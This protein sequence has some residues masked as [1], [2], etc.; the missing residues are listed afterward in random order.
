MRKEP[1][2][3]GDYVHVYNRGN[4]KLDIVRDEAD[5][6]RFLACLRYFNDKNP[7]ESIM[8]SFFEKKLKKDN[9]GL[10]MSDFHRQ[11]QV[12]G[13]PQNEKPQ[14]EIVHIIAYCLMPNHFHLLLKEIQFGGVTRFM[15][16]LGT[17]FTNYT[18]TK[19]KEAGRIFQGAYKAR[20]ITDEHY[21]QYADAYVQVLNPFEL[22]PDN[23][24]VKDFNR[25]FKQTIDY[26][27]SSLGECIGYR[28]FEI[29]DRKA[30]NKK[31]RLP[32]DEKSYRELAKDILNS[33]GIGKFLPEIKLED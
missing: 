25:A 16:K 1:F 24:P 13:W 15:R 32:N 19:Y 4:R 5:R 10:W 8:R 31:Y 14:K 17:G 2:D 21:L 22:L 6:W 11:A 26:P 30:I 29:L 23:L 33:G 18:N 7:G 12:F 9:S 27:F 28:N 3:V 20:L